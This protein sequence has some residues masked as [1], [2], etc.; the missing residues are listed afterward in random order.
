[1]FDVTNPL[2]KQEEPT[3][4]PVNDIPS[5]ATGQLVTVNVKAK[6]VDAPEKVKAKKAKV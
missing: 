3:M 5:L 4:V 2:A 6:I 1:M